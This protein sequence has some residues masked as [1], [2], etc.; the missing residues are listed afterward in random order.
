MAQDTKH[1]CD[2]LDCYDEIP[3][4]IW[5]KNQKVIDLQG[6]FPGQIII[7]LC[8]KHVAEFDKN[9]LPVKK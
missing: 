7:D 6:R 2:R 3:N 9:Y 1:T 5:E 8:D 4:F